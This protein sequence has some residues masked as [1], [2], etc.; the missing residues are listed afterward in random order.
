V[1]LENN[2]PLFG[3]LLKKVKIEQSQLNLIL[4]VIFFIKMK[5][6]RVNFQNAPK[7]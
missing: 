2:G 4:K 1:K 3:L 5:G 6:I 7:V